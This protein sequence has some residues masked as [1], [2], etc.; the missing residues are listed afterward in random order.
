MRK[1]L[2]VV[3]VAGVVVV[4]WMN[5]D[6]LGIVS[7]QAPPTVPEASSTPGSPAAPAP[8]LAP[9]VPKQHPAR[10][11]QAQ[12]IARYPALSRPNSEL[13]RKFLALYKEAQT[14]DPALLAQP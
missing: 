4:G 14:G 11:A 8:Q 6:K 2:G 1:L 12:A 10:E 3:L 13:N 7:P 5:R 9:T